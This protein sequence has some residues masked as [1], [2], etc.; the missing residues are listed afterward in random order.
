MLSS[1]RMPV[2]WPKGVPVAR[3]LDFQA[4]FRC[5]SRDSHA[6]RAHRLGMYSGLSKTFVETKTLAQNREKLEI[7]C[8]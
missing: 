4:A 1:L 3:S 7:A 6:T 2:W 8:N 5:V